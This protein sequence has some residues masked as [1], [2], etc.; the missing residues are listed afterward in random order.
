MRP[1]LELKLAEIDELLLEMGTLVEEQLNQA[2]IALTTH[3]V[4]LAEKVVLTDPKIDE[5]ERTIENKCLHTIALQNPLAGD[6]RKLSAVMKIITDLERIGDHCV[7][8]A[9]IVV[10]IGSEAHFKPLLDL[11]KMANIVQEMVN[12]SLD[13]YVRKDVA[14]ATL[15]AQRDDEV[16]E[17]YIT[18][19]KE[20]LN[21]I[22]EDKTHMD[23]I[24]SLLFIGRFLERIADHVTNVCEHSIFMING[25]RVS[26]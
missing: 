23:Q 3:N 13:S 6:L 26:F 16:D 2:I 18:I 15:T 8:I 22:H 25:K 7:N 9:E 21:Y 12:S 17:L 4:A 11:P 14:L 1:K 24:I 10:S 20:L 19:Y 5:L